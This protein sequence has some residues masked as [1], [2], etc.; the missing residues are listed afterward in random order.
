MAYFAS[1]LL[2]KLDEVDLMLPHFE[3]M[4]VTN[5]GLA[6]IWFSEKMVQA[7]PHHV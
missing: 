3:K 5:K 4:E 1:L 7:Q 6:T 2:G